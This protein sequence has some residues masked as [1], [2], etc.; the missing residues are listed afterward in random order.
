[1]TRREA[2]R[3]GGQG[4]SEKKRAALCLNGKKGGKASSHVRWHV[5]RGVIDPKCEFC[6]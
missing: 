3:V 4:C 6:K 2:G 1:M 5:R